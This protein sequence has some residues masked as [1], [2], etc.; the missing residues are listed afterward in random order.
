M[1]PERQ[2][3]LHT[4]N[5]TLLERDMREDRFSPALP[6]TK[7]FPE[8]SRIAAAVIAVADQWTAADVR[9]PATAELHS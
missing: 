1:K 3:D 6:V 7:I 4:A 5:A 8:F 9:F 2:T